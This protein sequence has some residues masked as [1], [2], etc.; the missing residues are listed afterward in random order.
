MSLESKTSAVPEKILTAL[1]LSN[2]A[3]SLVEEERSRR[4][5]GQLSIS[6]VSGIAF[7]NRVVGNKPIEDTL[8]LGCGI[9]LTVP[10][11]VSPSS[12]LVLLGYFENFLAKSPEELRQSTVIPTPREIEDFYPN[13]KALIRGFGIAALLDR[14]LVVGVTALDM[15]YD[16]GVLSSE[17]GRKTLIGLTGNSEDRFTAAE[18]I[19]SLNQ[20]GMTQRPPGDTLQAEVT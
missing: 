11:G 17:E 9:P 18:I 7:Y 5:Q 6:E 4:L 1:E 3:V 19:H 15:A 10:E 13:M 12:L 16:G 20:S 8:T 14:N 2:E